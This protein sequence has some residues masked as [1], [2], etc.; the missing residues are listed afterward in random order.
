M[1]RAQEQER[2]AINKDYTAARGEKDWYPGRIIGEG[3]VT[4]SFEILYDEQ[5]NGKLDRHPRVFPFL[6]KGM[7]SKKF[8]DGKELGH[9]VKM[10]R[11]PEN[12]FTWNSPLV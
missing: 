10:I 12:E 7:P 11:E 1:A 4:N 8:R 3:S 6:A 2:A 9:G 5:V